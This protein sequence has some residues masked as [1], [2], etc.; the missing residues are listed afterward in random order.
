MLPLLQAEGK[1]IT[2]QSATAISL[3]IYGFFF[4]FV[5]GQTRFRIAVKFHNTRKIQIYP[6]YSFYRSFNRTLSRLH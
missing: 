3:T 6:T 5:F 4:N 2:L 1:L